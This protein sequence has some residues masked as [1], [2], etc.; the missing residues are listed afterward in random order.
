MTPE[1]TYF[2]GVGDPNTGPIRLA[3][4]QLKVRDLPDIFLGD[5]NLTLELFHG[6]VVRAWYD[7]LSK[8]FE[9]L[10]TQFTN[11]ERDAISID[12]L[13][14]KQLLLDRSI[15][16]NLAQAV[17]VSVAKAFT[18]A[19]TDDQL[20]TVTKGLGRR[21]DAKTVAQIRVHTTVRNCFEHNGGIVRPDDLKRLGL[22]AITLTNDRA[23]PSNFVAG[24]LLTLSIWDLEDASDI[25]AGAATRLILK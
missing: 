3:R 13:Q 15:E 10:V 22:E 21:L 19:T 17:K 2:V 18:F 12:R 25:F 1:A 24:D 20:K 5:Q 8:T 14:V 16:P 9:Q 11:G 7:F 23:D 4:R 6:R